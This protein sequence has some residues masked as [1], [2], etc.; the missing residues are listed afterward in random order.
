MNIEEELAKLE[1][2]VEELEKAAKKYLRR[3][4]YI[5]IFWI[6][7]VSVLITVIYSLLKG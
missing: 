6:F 2:S 5:N 1:L 3:Q 7:F 4:R